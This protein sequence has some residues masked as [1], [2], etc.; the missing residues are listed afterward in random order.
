MFGQVFEDTESVTKLISILNSCA[1]IASYYNMSKT[2]DSLVTALC[3]SST[4]LQFTTKAALSPPSSPTAHTHHHGSISPRE[5][6]H[7]LIITFGKQ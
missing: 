2:L 5:H 6:I 3:Q 4:L 7:Q 1:F